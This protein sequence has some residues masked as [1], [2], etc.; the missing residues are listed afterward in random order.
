MI[1]H[2]FND[3]FSRGGLFKAMT[4]PR[5]GQITLQWFRQSRGGALT[6]EH[7]LQR[8]S[9]IR[10]CLK[11]NRVPKDNTDIDALGPYLVT[12]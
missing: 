4:T 1:E 9:G 2:K 5:A 11:R 12:Y 3:S 10:A 6:E 7:R 8:L